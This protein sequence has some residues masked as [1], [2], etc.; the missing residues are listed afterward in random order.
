MRPFLL[1]KQFQI[2]FI[3]IMISVIPLGIGLIWSLP[4]ATLGM[5]VI[6]R[7]LFGVSQTN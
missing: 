6:Y 4:F 5:A 3:I 1:K 2:H 7:N